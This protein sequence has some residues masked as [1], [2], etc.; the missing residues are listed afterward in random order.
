MTRPSPSSSPAGLS[1]GLRF[2]LISIRNCRETPPSCRRSLLE[3]SQGFSPRQVSLL[4]R[5]STSLTHLLP[6]RR[7]GGWVFRGGPG[8]LNT[9]SPPPHKLKPPK[10]SG[11]LTSAPAY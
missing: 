11:T 9:L 5:T 10:L 4:V 8:G 1:Q 7:G 2:L 3:I 6:L